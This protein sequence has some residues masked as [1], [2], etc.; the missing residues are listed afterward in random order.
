MTYFEFL[1][2]F[3]GGPII[4]LSLLTWRDVRRGRTLPV[5]LQNWRPWVA[6]AAHV[7]VALLYTTP[8]DN[9]LVATGVWWYNPQLVAGVVIGWVPIEEY[10]FFLVQPILT[11]LWLLWLGRRLAVPDYESRWA[12]RRWWPFGALGLLWLGSIAV[13][14]GGWTPGAYLGL[15]LVWA[16]PPI[17]FQLG[18][19]GDI[20]WRH[21]ALVGAV[22]A[23]ST[24]YLSL[25]DAVAISS[26]T[27]TI[28][29]AQSLN[30]Y[31]GGV[32]PVEEFI[33]F[34]VTN[35]LLTFGL[36]LVLA[37]Q[38]QERLNPALRQQLTRLLPQAN[39]V[40]R[41]QC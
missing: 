7:L 28:D 5:E 38:S 22:I 10:I 33:F 16:L 32:L 26:G 4:G 21:R 40:G 36:V 25:A 23:S 14:A 41:N 2:I 31:L 20:L 3:L 24:L 11:S 6:I 12:G 27:W 18:F 13:L 35:I 30:I 8:W 15:I 37:R 19:G 17:L 1:A 9:Y 29:P 34:L 39:R